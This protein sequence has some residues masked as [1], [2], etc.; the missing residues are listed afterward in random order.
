MAYY[1]DMK[2]I[3]TSENNLASALPEPAA[4]AIGRM[5]NACCKIKF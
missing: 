4:N 1:A 5:R 2:V 3:D